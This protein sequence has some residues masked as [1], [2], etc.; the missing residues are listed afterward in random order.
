MAD[1]DEQAQGFLNYKGRM[2]NHLEMV[3]RP[4]ERQA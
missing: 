4:G 3:Y 1:L 2:L